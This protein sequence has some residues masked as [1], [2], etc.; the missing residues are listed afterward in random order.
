MCLSTVYQRSG[1]QQKE[2]MKDVVRI[3]A[4][5]KGFRVI[6]LFGKSV[7]VEGAVKTVDLVEEHFVVIE[8]ELTSE[9]NSLAFS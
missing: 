7:F 2:I 5:A 8:K 3:E 1:N 4:E 9:Q 6:D